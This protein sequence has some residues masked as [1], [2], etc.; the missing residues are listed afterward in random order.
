[1][2]VSGLLFPQF[3]SK[4]KMAASLRLARREAA[5]VAFNAE[6][7]RNGYVFWSEISGRCIYFLNNRL[8]LCSQFRQSPR[9]TSP[10]LREL[11]P[12]AW[13]VTVRGKVSHLQASVVPSLGV[14]WL[15]NV[16]I[17]FSSEWSCVIAA[18]FLRGQVHLPYWIDKVY[19]M[20]YP[21]WV[22]Y[23]FHFISGVQYKYCWLGL[24]KVAF[25][26]KQEKKLKF[27]ICSFWK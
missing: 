21:T 5:F 18:C 6:F 17:Q 27:C 4:F 10:H 23:V 1:M 12:Q 16:L 11:C 8:S 2:F 19:S 9:R 26:K 24:S 7:E 3:I 25:N 20:L 14:F 15:F 22:T 13:R